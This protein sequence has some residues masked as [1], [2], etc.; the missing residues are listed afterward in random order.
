MDQYVSCQYTV[1]IA[2]IFA[3]EEEEEE[4]EEK[5]SLPYL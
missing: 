2:S 3:E 4:E 5:L 1:V